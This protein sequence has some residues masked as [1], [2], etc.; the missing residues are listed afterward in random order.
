MALAIRTDSNTY[1]EFKYKFLQSGN[2]PA[3]RT[4]AN[5]YALVYSSVIFRGFAK[6]VL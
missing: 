2:V 5:A 4:D 6:V 3:I 1:A